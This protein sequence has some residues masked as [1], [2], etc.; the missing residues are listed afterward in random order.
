M[1]DLF[2]WVNYPWMKVLDPALLMKACHHYAI[3][4][5]EEE[6]NGVSF[7]K[8]AEIQYHRQTFCV[9]EQKLQVC[10]WHKK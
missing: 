6:W 1:I 9:G 7:C 5:N 4:E 3:I 8:W 10:W 2:S